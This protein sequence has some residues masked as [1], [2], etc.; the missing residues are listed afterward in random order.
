MR[1]VAASDP[2]ARCHTRTKRSG[3]CATT[4]PAAPAAVGVSDRRSRWP[5]RHPT[6]RRGHG[7]YPWRALGGGTRVALREAPM[8]RS[9]KAVV[10]SRVQV[11]AYRAAAHDLERRTDHALDCRVFRTGVVDDPPGRTAQ[12]STCIR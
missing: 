5:V 1:T 6:R 7:E 10:M 9:D 12:L 3:G 4:F 8:S 2:I 11:L